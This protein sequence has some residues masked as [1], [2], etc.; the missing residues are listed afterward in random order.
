MQLQSWAKTFAWR[1]QVRKAALQASGHINEKR[2]ARGLK[3]RPV[4]AVVIGFP[5]VGKSAL[6]NRLLNR[7]VADSAPRPGVTRNLQWLRLGA[8]LDLLDAPGGAWQLHLLPSTDV[9]P[10]AR[11]IRRQR[12][13]ALSGLV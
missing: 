2:A 7:R 10:P 12:L 8:E 4:R 3:P 5:N 6:I 9:A 11:L 13:P 1:G